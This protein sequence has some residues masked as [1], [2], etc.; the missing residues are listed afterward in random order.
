M[1]VFD[2]NMNN[3]RFALKAV[4]A[5]PD[6]Y[7]LPLMNDDTASAIIKQLFVPIKGR[8]THLNADDTKELF[9]IQSLDDISE[10][11][12]LSRKQLAVSS[13]VYY[14]A[15][16]DGTPDRNKGALRKVTQ[17][18]GMGN[19]A[20][21]YINNV[22]SAAGISHI[23][24]GGIGG[25]GGSE[26][27]ISE[28][29][30]VLQAETVVSEAVPDPVQPSEAVQAVTVLSSLA[31]TRQIK[32]EQE[33][34]AEQDA[35]RRAVE[36]HQTRSIKS[37]KE[38]AKES[39]IHTNANE[40]TPSGFSKDGF[41][42]YD[43]LKEIQEEEPDPWLIEGLFRKGSIVSIPAQ[44]NDGKSM[45]LL[46]AFGAIASGSRFLPDKDGNGG[47]QTEQGACIYIDF[48]GDRDDTVSRVL[49]TLNYFS[50]YSGMDIKDIPL[51]VKYMPIDWSGSDDNVPTLIY[52]AIT[53]L[54]APYDKP[55]AIGIDTYTAFSDVENENDR[56]QA[57]KVFQRLKKLKAKFAETGTTIF[58]TQHLR[59]LNGKSFDTITMDDISGAGS[60][61]GALSDIWMLGTSTDNKDKKLLKQVKAK[62][63]A[64]QNDTKV[65]E[66]RYDNNPDGTLSSF[67]FVLL[68]GD[69]AEAV[70]KKQQAK[71]KSSDKEKENQVLAFIAQHQPCS[72]SRIWKPEYPDRL[73]MTYATTKAITDSLIAS[74][75][76]FQNSDGRFM[77]NPYHR[78]VT[79]E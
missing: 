41:W 56:A 11:E 10:L 9:G 79:E 35:G 46:N 61:A 59:K 76:I 16:F 15:R 29:S 13:I 60:Q 17:C 20:E 4:Q 52:E 38:S 69:D 30:R 71:K 5:L 67:T 43:I 21:T 40:N 51:I 32:T 68:S 48:E 39:P 72:L 31:D 57:T 37:V 73:K 19:D 75:A 45:L 12:K 50:G 49:A 63:R 2:M 55:V 58:V 42:N 77:I 34:D 23:P 62:A 74:S 28:I 44:Q 27:E 78:T 64:L 14:K 33:K 47:F 18:F 8:N 1:A 7:F 6:E 36:A 25:G 70:V 24:Q 53:A 26:N 22:C 3:I 54:P 66:F 65:L